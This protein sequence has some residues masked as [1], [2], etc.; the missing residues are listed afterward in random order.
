MKILDFFYDFL[1]LK[2]LILFFVFSYFFMKIC[3]PQDT[4]VFHSITKP[5]IEKHWLDIGIGAGID[6]GFLGMKLSFLPIPN[7][8]I[9]GSFG[10]CYVY[11]YTG[12]HSVGSAWNI[13]STIH[14]LPST[15]KYLIRPN[16]KIM[17]GINTGIYVEG[18]YFYSMTF[19]GWTPGVGIEM[20]YGKQRR[21]GYDFDINVPL[22]SQAYYEQATMIRN[23]PDIIEF[24]EPWPVLF[25]WGFHF[26]F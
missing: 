3:Y 19:I 8:S 17:Y 16:L 12:F 4:L 6:Y 9:D 15:S 20:M 26:E 22:R 5:E 11:G 21:F 25:S 10:Y 2:K 18:D 23:D 13:G 24:K 14:I 1:W 7:F